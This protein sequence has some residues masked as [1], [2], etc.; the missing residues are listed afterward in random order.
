MN[1]ENV[2]FGGQGKLVGK[3]DGRLNLLREEIPQIPTPARQVVG[4]LSSLSTPAEI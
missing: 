4:E 1:Q 3:I 2:F